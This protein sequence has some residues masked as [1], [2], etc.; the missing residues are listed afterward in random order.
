MKR[1]AVAL[2]L[3]ALQACAPALGTTPRSTLRAYGDAIAEG[4]ADDA[5]KMLSTDAQR[6]IPLAAFREM[7]A[8]NRAE[9][10]ELGKTLARD[11]GD[12]YVTAVVPL[13]NGDLILLVYEDGRWRVDGGALEFY[14]QAT[15]R[16]AIIGFVKAV[17]RSRWDVLLKYTPDAHKEG[18][19]PDRLA[20]AWSEKSEDGRKLREVILE[21]EKSFPTA[22]FEETGDRATMMYGAASATVLFVREHGSW[23]IEDIPIR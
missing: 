21:I 14:S 4:R 12:P 22:R 2:I 3:F 19:T 8:K 10:L 18:L 1:T 17:K 15:P 6:A 11:P 7:V 23:K 20:S 9:A 16:Q 13:P 5:Y